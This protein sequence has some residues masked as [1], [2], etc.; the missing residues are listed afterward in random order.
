M[1]VKIKGL[2]FV[3]FA[4]AILSANAMADDTNTVTSK[5]YTEATYQHKS[6]R[7]V[8]WAN[9]TAEEKTAALASDAL[10]PSMK[11]LDAEMDA[12]TTAIT[13]TNNAA[14]VKSTAN[15]QLGGEGGSWKSVEAGTYV[16]APVQGTTANDA[17]IDIKA[18]KIADTVAKIDLGGAPLTTAGAVEGYVN[19]RSV[20]VNGTALT[21]NTNKEVDVTV[22]EGTAD[23]TV[24]V[25][26]T[27]VAV[28]NAEVTT[29]KAAAIVTDS[30]SLDYNSNSTDK[31]ASTKAVYDYVQAQTNGNTIPQQDATICD[32]THPCALI[33]ENGTLSWKRL[34]QAGD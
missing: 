11:T 19:V 28:H 6:D 23:G 30:T 15:Y 7:V 2:V 26:G 10:Y 16:A 13:N 9:K 25:N 24:K 18:D 22:I 3:G 14:Q 8:D 29:D 21:P 5:A 17:K 27:D 33:N 20:K 12:L 31:Y 4:A 34:A 1:K 32:A